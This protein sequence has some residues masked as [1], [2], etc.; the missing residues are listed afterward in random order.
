[1][2]RTLER[3][4]A[5]LLDQ[6]R[7]REA[8]PLIEQCLGVYESRY[9]PRHPTMATATATA[10]RARALLG[11]REAA[12]ALFRKA[13]DLQRQVRPKPHVTT[14][15]ILLAYGEALTSWNRAAEAEPLLREA[16]VQAEASLPAGHFRRGQ[17]EKALRAARGR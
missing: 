9:G 13:L 4:A 1:V 8:R 12:D 3:H 11:E 14:V 15:E 10:A 2:A 5:A 16:L 17:V 7:P 6:G